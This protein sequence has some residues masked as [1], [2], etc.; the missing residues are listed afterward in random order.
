MWFIMNDFTFNAHRVY[1][2]QIIIDTLDKCEI[3]EFSYIKDFDTKCVCGE[4]MGVC[5]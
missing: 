1:T 4:K 3:L 5:K 2:P